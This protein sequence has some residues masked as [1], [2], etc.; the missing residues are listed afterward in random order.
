MP[1]LIA[2]PLMQITS[3]ALAYAA[4]KLTM[5]IKFRYSFK[6]DLNF[7]SKQLK[8]HENLSRS[9]LHY[10]TEAANCDSYN[11][12]LEIAVE[13][14]SFLAVRE[15]L[16]K[17]QYVAERL[18]SADINDEVTFSNLVNTAI[19]K[20]YKDIIVLLRLFKYYYIEGKIYYDGDSALKDY[21][22]CLGSE[23]FLEDVL[24]NVVRYGN[25]SMLDHLLSDYKKGPYEE[26]EYQYTTNN[27][28]NLEQKNEER[29]LGFG[30]ASVEL[31]HKMLI[32]A[33]RRK[34]TKN[35]L[36]AARIILKKIKYLAETYEQLQPDLLARA[37]LS[38]Y[39]HQ[40]S[41]I[42]KMILDIG[43][44][45]NDHISYEL[46]EII[47]QT[48][49]FPFDHVE[50]FENHLKN[51]N[52]NAAM[53][54]LTPGFL[55]YL[56]SQ[57]AE[58]VN[59]PANNLLNERQRR[60]IRD[61]HKVV[62]KVVCRLLHYS[63]SFTTFLVQQGSNYLT[64]LQLLNIV[65]DS[66]RFPGLEYLRLVILKF[67]E[68]RLPHREKQSLQYLAKGS[69]F[70]WN[71]IRRGWFISYFQRHSFN[72]ELFSVIIKHPYWMKWKEQIITLILCIKRA[73]KNS[74]QD[75]TKNTFLSASELREIQ[76]MYGLFRTISIYGTCSS[77]PLRI[78]KSYYPLIN[79]IHMKHKAGIKEIENICRKGQP[80]L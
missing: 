49:T 16:F 70:F 60:K 80:K 79:A 52:F 30:D 5:L 62:H 56:I 40:Y 12:I 54:F 46:V 27:H 77:F 17:N 3:P 59:P 74:I 57:Y 6:Q 22:L 42:F 21:V 11:Q 28:I 75:V 25:P 13:E 50:I 41:E 61:T 24:L 65:N 8:G 63:D 71:C 45:N 51:P 23:A 38:A 78:Q 48:S 66:R 7:I 73:Y 35:R 20:G 64:S 26:Y 31:V 44:A 55:K 14:G 19:K 43:I 4:I 15:L 53:A 47:S 34:E 10:I 68:L 76:R 36:E 33:I 9:S 29:N 58:R 39:H 2:A 37:A 32:L 72:Q 18:I 69:P 67:N 1:L